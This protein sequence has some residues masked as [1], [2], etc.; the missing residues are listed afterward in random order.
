MSLT[1]CYIT[2]RPKPE[3]Q[4][5][6]DS[7]RN[8]PAIVDQ[9]IVVD[10]FADIAER[11]EQFHQLS[12][13]ACFQF[14]HVEPKPTV[15]QGKHRLTKEN[16][17]AAS[18]SRNT[19]ICLCKSDWIC[20]L[21]DRS[22]LMPGWMAAVNEAIA[23]NYTVFGSYQK[24]I[25]MTVENGTIKEVG[26][27]SGEDCREKY[28]IEH[29]NSKA[30]VKC[31]GEWSFGCTLAVPLEWALQVN[32]YEELMDGLGFEDIYFGK[33]LEANGYDCRFDLRMKIIEDRTGSE[34]GTRMEKTSKQKIPDDPNAKD[35]AALKRS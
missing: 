24:R 1:I 25:G 34:I 23:G 35:F 13:D 5:F 28:V 18:N 16:W 31:P 22:V 14:V 20:F 6:F 7:L 4:W 17:W 26:T 2:S 8:Q 15:W 21:D 19:G 12:K 10:L 32:G 33:S 3:I 9:I 30:P 11:R 29:W 27:V